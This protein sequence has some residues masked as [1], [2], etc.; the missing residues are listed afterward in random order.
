[1]KSNRFDFL[2][3]SDEA[4]QAPLAD[5]AA[6]IVPAL[7]P[8]QSTTQVPS[9][10]ARHVDVTTAAVSPRRRTEPVRLA[11]VRVEPQPRIAQPEEP[12][13]TPWVANRVLKAVE[14]FGQR[15][16]KAGEFNFPTGLAVDS[17][18]ILWVADS[19]NNRLQRITPDGGVAVVGTRGLNRGQFMMPMAVAVD[20]DRSF[21]VIEQGNHRIQKFSSEGV[22]QFVAGRPGSRPGELRSPMGIAINPDTRE[23]L[24]A[25]TGNARVQR[26]D[27]D[28]RFLGII[29]NEDPVRPGLSNPQA[30]ACDS[31][32]RIYV[33]DTLARQ[34]VQYDQVGRALGYYGGPIGPG[35]FPG[36]ATLRLD[37]PRAIGCSSIGK[38]FVSDAQRGAGSIIVIDIASGNVEASISKPGRSLGPLSR[39]CGLAVAPVTSEGVS[40]GDIY[41]ADT[42]NHRI[43]RFAWT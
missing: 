1:M 11:E 26:F 8:Q 28:G 12:R 41:L 33:A 24:V 10:P 37:E 23:I 9:Q 27:H 21:Y 14:V 19:Y 16:D 6:D 18:G 42:M 38:L 39:P 34:I 2:E 43:I 31:E 29:G 20:A 36:S 30:I 40:T 17:T 15:G 35:Q 7:P 22:L 32:G 13:P 5:D 4:E 25:D 3:L